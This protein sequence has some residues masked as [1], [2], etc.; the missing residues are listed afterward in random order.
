[1]V[2]PTNNSFVLQKNKNKIWTKFVLF[3]AARRNLDIIKKLFI[4]SVKPNN[5][6]DMKELL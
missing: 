5:V 2:S 3:N 6:T 4:P 1:M